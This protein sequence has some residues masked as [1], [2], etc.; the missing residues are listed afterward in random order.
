MVTLPNDLNEAAA[1]AIAATQAAL[2]DGQTRLQIELKI[3]ELKIQPIAQQ[4]IFDGFAD[5]GSKLR[6]FFPD[7]GSAAL[8]RRDWGETAFQIRGIS[9]VNAAI[10]E[11]EGTFIFVEPSAVE[12]E[13]VEKLCNE[14]GDRPVILLNPQLE[15]V[16]IVGIGYAGRKLRDR[17]LSTLLSCYYIRPLDDT[18][19]VFHAYPNAWE[20][21]LETDGIY[22]KI[23][24]FAERPTSEQLDRIFFSG[25]EDESETN[26]RPKKNG[27]LTQMQRF[28]N[29]LSS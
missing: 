23:A 10:Q 28:F 7:A 17:F 5:L 15:D 2:A 6:V 29:A 13:A 25:A 14:A 12:V 26:Q 16:S 24:D 11:E 8:A 20:A 22:N 27:F 1:Q 9:D 3:P 21:W 18:A 4:F 19:A